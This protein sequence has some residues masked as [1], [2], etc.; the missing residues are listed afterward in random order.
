M[1]LLLLLLFAT[2]IPQNSDFLNEQLKYSRVRTAKAQKD[3]IV[4]NV[5]RLKDIDYPS[6]NI[7]IRIFKSEAILEIWAYSK[8]ET[9]FK[10]VT[11]YDICSLSGILGPKRK[12]GDLQI[13][14]GIYYISHF[15]PFSNFYLSLKINYPNQSD[16]ILG[17]KQDLGGDIFI[18]GDCVTIGCIPINDEYIKELY[19][20]TVQ[21]KSKGQNRIPV[22]IFPAKLEESKMI[23]LKNR[24][25]SGLINFWNNLKSIYDYFE[26]YKTIPDI[27]VDEKG[28]YI[29]DNDG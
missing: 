18:H 24:Y 25:N 6:N 23:I 2:L 7:F 26:D 20:I 5:F 16:R 13:P 15:N 11:T 22:H 29:I 27:K 19:W 10:L 3:S 8:G 28:K 12:R 17:Y 1:K 21:A 4:K 9:H 14:E